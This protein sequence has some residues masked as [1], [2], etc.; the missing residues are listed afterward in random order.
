MALDTSNPPIQ[1]NLTAPA[2]NAILSGQPATLTPGSEAPTLAGPQSP[3]MGPAA[4]APGAP[5][6]GVAGASISS[7]QIS[8]TARPAGTPSV[9]KNILMGALQGLAN[10]GRSGT[11]AGGLAEGAAGVEAARQRDIENQQAATQLQFESLKAA[12]SVAVAAQQANEIA[13]QNQET[14]QALQDHAEALDAMR[15]AFGLP[16][17][18]ATVSENHDLGMH[19]QAAGVLQN[20]AAQNPSGK[21]GEVVISQKPVDGHQI[22][23]YSAPTPASLQQTPNSYL[24]LVNSARAVN[25]QPALSQQ[26]WS[27]G[28]GTIQPNFSD[29]NKS[30]S[31]Q[32]AWQ[33]G[34]VQAAQKTLYS[35]PTPT[36]SIAKDS[37]IAASLDQ[38]LASYKKS[39]NPDPNVVT[40]LTN[41]NAAFSAAISDAQDRINKANAAAIRS[42]QAAKGSDTGNDSALVDQIGLGKM[43]LERLDYLA[44]RNPKLLDD[45]SAKYP[46]FDGSKI[47][48]YVKTYQDFTSGKTSV[49]LNSGATALKHL[50]ELRALNTDTSRIR[51][52]SDYNAYQNKLNTV[53]GELIK[54]YG[55]PDTNQSVD[56]LKKGLGA[57]FNRDSAIVEQAK[58]MGDKLASYQQTWE[59]AAPS[60][61]YQAPLPAIDNDAKT[62]LASLDPDFVSQHPAFAPVKSAPFNPSDVVRTGTLRGAKVYQLKNGSIVDSTGKQVVQ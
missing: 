36:G 26:E 19:T 60:K 31:A 20:L 3:D 55:M 30:I 35:I 34:Q 12:H 53:V 15:K 17:P 1:T 46:D 6:P 10:S 51:G 29:P 25:G 18:N 52:T 8:A 11:F 14:A 13:L 43:P 40:L 16:E 54:F 27:T 33:S 28:Q 5:V 44:T 9:W 49:A 7:D 62:A 47:K 56:A 4:G 58:S 48:S 23:V 39:L 21:I 24:K 45:V 38:Q 22:D 57:F 37:A 2:D 32:S 41:R 61:S 50:A 42:N 59:N